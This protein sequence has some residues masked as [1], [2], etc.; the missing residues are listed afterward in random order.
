MSKALT[1]NEL[2]GRRKVMQ[3]VVVSDK[4]DKTIVVLVEDQIIAHQGP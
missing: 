2:R 1:A 4:M 3:G